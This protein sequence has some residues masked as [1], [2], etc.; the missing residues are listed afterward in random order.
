MASEAAGGEFVAARIRQARAVFCFG[1][2]RSVYNGQMVEVQ[3]CFSVFNGIDRLGLD[4]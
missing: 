3:G 1:R 2:T 4:P